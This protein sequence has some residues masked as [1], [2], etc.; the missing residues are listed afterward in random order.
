[1]QLGKLGVFYFVQNLSAPQLTELTRRCEELGYSALWYPEARGAESL[2]MGGFLLANSRKL[3]VASGIANIYARD[4][5]TM[6]W[7]QHQLTKLYGERFLLGIGVSHAPMVQ[8]LR[9]HA[10]GKPVPAMRAFLDGMERA[11]SLAAPLPSRPPL[12]LAALGPLMMALARQRADG[13][14]PYNV[15]PEHSAKAREILGPGKWLCVEQK[16]CVTR[17]ASQARDVARKIMKVYLELPHYV[18]NWRRLGFGERDLAGGGSDGFLD[19][20]VAWGDAAAVRRRIQEHWDAGADHVCIQPLRADGSPLPDYDAM[21]DL[22][23]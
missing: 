8:G 11:A 1:M 5:F 3:I 13:A 2:S 18:E 22:A 21:K 6:K 23:G 15:T 16:V 4:P 17:Q 19:A 14:H 7:G 10:Y 20:M 9:G 12:V